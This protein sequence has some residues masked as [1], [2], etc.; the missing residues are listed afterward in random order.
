M[1]LHHH[2]HTAA[3][4]WLSLFHMTVF[5]YLNLIKLQKNSWYS[6]LAYSVSLNIAFP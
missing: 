2:T 3:V 6:V 1:N 4:L 5:E